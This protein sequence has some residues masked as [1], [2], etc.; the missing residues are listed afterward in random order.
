MNK[1]DASSPTLRAVPLATEVARVGSTAGQAVLG[2]GRFAMRSSVRGP[3]GAR[4]RAARETRETFARLGPTYVKFGQLI[5]SSP[6]VF[7]EVLAT[8]F[9]GL[10][11]RVPPADPVEIRR[12]FV[13]EFGEGPESIFTEFDPKPIASASIAQVHRATLRSGEDVVVK[14]QRPGIKVRLAADLRIL[15]RV[16]AVL[17]WSVYG[18]MLNAQ[19]I[20]SEFEANLNDELDFRDEARAMEQ[21]YAAVKDST[22]SAKVR[23]PKVYWMFT[24]S[25]VLTLERV[26]AIR[27]DDLSAIAAAGHRGEDLIRTLLLS[28]L[29]SAFHGGIFHGDLHAGNVWVDHDGRLVYLDFGIVG[30]FDSATRVLLRQLVSDLLIRRD[31]DAAGRALQQMGAVRRS[32]LPDT[33]A[34]DIATFVAPVG[35][36]ALGS[37]SYGSL[38]GQLT[39]LAKKHDARLPR[40]LVLVAKQLLYVEGYMKQLAP[41][42]RP[43]VDPEVLK[44]FAGLVREAEAERARMPSAAIG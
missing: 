12:V 2:L 16:A 11:D 28:L 23:T 4:R 20:V 33:T 14:I 1:H 31:Y 42:W 35:V 36:T 32:R 22:Y 24:G 17:E 18:R 6:G 38:V 41:N 40:E 34:N 44:F 13:E 27:I 29:E 9:R 30:R 10:L 15:R 25:R 3:S 39:E 37:L 26:D 5:A 21:W 7:P 8:E 19:E 43:F